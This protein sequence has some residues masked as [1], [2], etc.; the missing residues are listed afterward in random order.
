VVV[1]STAAVLARL[2]RFSGNM[3]AELPP[4][5]VALP[6]VRRLLVDAGVAFRIV[7]GVAVVHHGYARTTEDV[8]V[9]VEA[10][11]LSRLDA[12]LEAH[13]FER[14]AARRLQH[15]ASGVRV[16]VLVAGELFRAPARACIRRPDRPARARATRR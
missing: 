5:D 13:G 11:G 7:G 3:S 14:A 10:D 16:D 12:A 6:E 4:V 8:D 9:L 1:D 2:R 15:V